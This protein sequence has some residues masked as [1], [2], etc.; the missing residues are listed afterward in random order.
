[1]PWKAG[2]QSFELGPRPESSEE[3]EDVPAAFEQ[4]VFNLRA[5]PLD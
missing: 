5:E 3:V 4:L 2:K 1:M